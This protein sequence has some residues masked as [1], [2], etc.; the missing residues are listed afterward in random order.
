ML[1]ILFEMCLSSE[2]VY[3]LHNRAFLFEDILINLMFVSPP[4]KFFCFIF[5]NKIITIIVFRH[6]LSTE[7]LKCS[8]IN[9]KKIV[10]RIRTGFACMRPMSEVLV[11][12]S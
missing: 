5:V 1:C 3:N 4:Y 10:L 8:A 2:L 12:N 9:Q 11:A 6:A 7:Y